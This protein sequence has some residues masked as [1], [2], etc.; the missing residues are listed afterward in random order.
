MMA[1]LVQYRVYFLAGLLLLALGCAPYLK[2]G[3]RV[4]NALQIWFV[5]DDPL[6]EGYRQFQSLFGS[7]ERIA[8][9]IHREEGVVQPA[10]FSQ[11]KQA[12]SDVSTL[13]G[14]EKVSSLV[15]AKTLKTIKG[16]TAYQAVFPDA[17]DKVDTDSLQEVL[18]TAPGITDLYINREGTTLQVIVQLA[19]LGEIE[20]YMAQ[21][22]SNIRS[23]FVSAFPDSRVALGGTTV[24]Y[25]GLNALTQHDFGVYLGGGLV[26][27]V[28]LLALF[29]RN[30]RVLLFSLA[31]ITLTLWVS[32]GIYGFMGYSMN[33]VA[34]IAPLI[35]TMICLLD[36]IHLLNRHRQD[37]PV[38]HTLNQVFRPCIFTSLTT[39]AGFMALYF[40][41]LQILRQFGI[42]V[43]TGVITA[44]VVSFVLAAFFLPGL[45]GQRSSVAIWPH[46]LG[47]IGMN[48]PA[49]VLI[50]FVMLSGIMLWGTFQL[51]ANT[52]TLGYLPDD[53]PVVQDHQAIQAYWGHY[54]PVDYI[55]RPGKGYA[56]TDEPVIRAMLN[57][58][59]S[60]NDLPGVDTCYSFHQ[61]YTRSFPLMY[62]P[63]WSGKLTNRNIDRHTR[64][65]V[66]T[67]SA[68][69]S[70]WVNQERGKLTLIGAV[71]STNRLNHLLNRVNRLATDHLGEKAL[72]IPAGYIPLYASIVD[73]VV[74]AQV[75]SFF[76]ALGVVALL[77]LVLVRGN[78]RLWV[79][80]VI[81]TVV[82]ALAVLGFMGW[83]GITLDVASA[84]IAAITLGIGIDDT[85]HLLHHYQRHEND[86]PNALAGTQRM[87]GRAIQQTTV[88]LIAGFGVMSFASAVTV[89]YF[90]LL[91]MVALTFAFFTV[92]LLVPALITRLNNAP[93]DPDPHST[94][95]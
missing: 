35:L 31:T 84:M 7:D 2:Q 42:L 54:F 33:L 11:L 49:V 81:S 82:P 41:P 45:K 52:Y 95:P 63:F 51:E 89:R 40:T 12:V 10:M 29:Y 76:L 69:L 32:L 94:I 72:L 71:M 65:M 6:Q 78:F 24:I 22:V 46:R 70:Q 20:Q 91:L 19:P 4:S 48:K 75:N 62:G 74:E 50:A 38:T 30:F 37:Q 25:A 67:D 92:S 18:R 56:I 79:T 73:Y 9:I 28:L 43:S 58:E 34:A 88:L 8:V 14:V 36:T 83:A 66:E 55:V 93:H 23:A 64:R 15:H 39:A 13:K 21:L 47:R 1:H 86:Y 16:K 61:L 59:H 53:H 68:L 77:L 27:M 57:F 5:D 80:G 44:L 60:V 3:L 26:T 17:W 90:G 85:I 87:V